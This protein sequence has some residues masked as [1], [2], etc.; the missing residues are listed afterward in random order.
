[1]A[2]IKSGWA[3]C[4]VCGKEF[5]IVGNRKKCCSKACGEE[6]S[7]RQCYERGKARYR[8]LSPEQK[9]ELAMKRKQAKPKSKRHNGTEVQNELVRVAA[10]AKQHGMSYGQYVAKSERRRDGKND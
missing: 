1:M 2:E 6:R 3:V 7:R 8:A 9:K 10:E 4:S 5:E